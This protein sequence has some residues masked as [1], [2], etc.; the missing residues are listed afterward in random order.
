MDMTGTW[1]ITH[2]MTFRDDGK[3]IW[4]SM[5]GFLETNKD[6][7]DAALY[8][9]MTLVFRENG[10]VLHVMPLPEDLTEEDIKEMVDSGE[11]ELFG[12]GCAVVEKKRWKEENGK[13]WYD[14]GTV[15]TVGETPVD[16][17]TEIL[18]LENGGVEVLTMR[19]K[20]EE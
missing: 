10:E 7:P 1:K 9:G 8:A 18:P 4:E 3:K 6:D 14:T 2:L 13:A 11:A 17:W 5:E 12:E 16:P 19:L 20:R 15:G